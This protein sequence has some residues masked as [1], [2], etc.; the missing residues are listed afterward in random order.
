[1]SRRLAAA[2]PGQE[3][4]GPPDMNDGGSFFGGCSWGFG[5]RYEGGGNANRQFVQ[6]MGCWVRDGEVVLGKLR[7]W[8]LGKWSLSVG[9]GR[10]A[11]TTVAGGIASVGCG[12]VV[13]SFKDEDYG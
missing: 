1:M 5:C 13:G 10:D 4:A 6:V 3:L 11:D 8:L 12:R 2:Q 7:S 9:A